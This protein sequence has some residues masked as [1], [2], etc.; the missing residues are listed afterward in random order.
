MSG[1]QTTKRYTNRPSPPYPANKN[2]ARTK[3]GN[4]GRY[5]TSVPASNGVCR[6]VHSD[7]EA[8]PFEYRKHSWEELREARLERTVQTRRQTSKSTKKKAAKR[9]SVSPRSKKGSRSKSPCSRGKKVVHRK[10]YTRA[11]GT[12]VKATTY[13]VKA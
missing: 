13:C 12:R 9:R 11:D 4:D 3:L 6:W 10:A 5:W 8:I 7:S 2:C 1:R